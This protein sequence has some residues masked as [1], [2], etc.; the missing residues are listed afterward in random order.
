[1]TEPGIYLVDYQIINS[2]YI[3]VLGMWAPVKI[4]VNS[5][6]WIINISEKLCF[7]KH[8]FYN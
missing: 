3:L 6:R 7:L 8:F 2:C 5:F 1:M 4:E